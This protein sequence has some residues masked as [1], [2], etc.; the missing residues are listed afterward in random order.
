MKRTT[1]NGSFVTSATAL[2]DAAL[3][4]AALVIAGG[5]REQPAVWPLSASQLSI[6]PSLCASGSVCQLFQLLFSQCLCAMMIII[7]GSA[8][9]HTQHLLVCQL[10]LRVI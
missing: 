3:V 6:P 10:M 7:I 9:T 4:D 1:T 5:A 8:H 2:V